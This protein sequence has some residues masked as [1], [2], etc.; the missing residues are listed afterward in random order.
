MRE[1]F[2]L[3]HVASSATNPRKVAQALAD[4]EQSPSLTH[5][6]VLLFIDPRDLP[7]KFFQDAPGK[8]SE[9]TQLL[10]N[11]SKASKFLEARLKNGF[12]FNLTAMQLLYWV[13]VIRVT[14][15]MYRSDIPGVLLGYQHQVMGLAGCGEL[16]HA[17]Q[18]FH[19]L[20]AVQDAY[21]IEVAK[22][23]V[24]Q[25][26]FAEFDNHAQHPDDAPA[27]ETPPPTPSAEGLVVYSPFSGRLVPLS[28][29]SDNNFARG[30]VGKGYAVEPNEG[31]LYAPVTGTVVAINSFG[32]AYT[33]KA[34]NP[35]GAG[36][37]EAG[38][39]V[40]ILI[41]IGIKTWKLSSKHFRVAV[42]V[43][44]QVT[45][46]DLLCEFDLDAINNAGGG[47]ISSPVVI[48]NYRAS[49]SFKPAPKVSL[50]GHINAG[51]PLMII[52]RNP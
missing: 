31:R 6:C 29:V 39:E 15:A 43:G 30:L 19:H 13:G 25:Q 36:G 5:F 24:L 17:R 14:H 23:N 18:L 44:E 28:H 4:Y 37:A 16:A 52:P 26:H 9:L 8:Y 20:V 47:D 40:T 51:D 10:T 41:H 2:V 50:P 45:A 34:L 1:I 42:G 46:G 48:T 49:R 38:P 12:P 21:G 11:R 33:I 7:A 27:A 32:Y 3:N 35:N 22:V